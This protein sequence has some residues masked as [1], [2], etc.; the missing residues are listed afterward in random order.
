M[1]QPETLR[2][3]IPTGPRPDNY[4]VL[5]PGAG[6][7]SLGRHV[8]HDPQSR[9]YPFRAA[10]ATLAAVYH[11]R[12]VPIFDQGQLG[13]CTGNAGLGILATGPYWNDL[14]VGQQ[15]GGLAGG[16]YT[17]DEDGAKQLYS[18]VTADDDFPG[19]WPPSDTGSD[20]LSVGK[21]LVK[22]GVILGY[23]HTFDLT[24][25]L[26]ALQQFP[27]LVGTVWTD[28]MFYPDAL[29]RIGIS[30]PV[31]GGHEWIVDEFVPPGYISRGG[32]VLSTIE[33]CIG[34]TTSWSAAFGVAGR[35]YLTT[36]NFGKLLKQD[37]DV[38][39]LTPP[40]APAPTPE[41]VPGE[42]PTA[43]DVAAKVRQLLTDLGL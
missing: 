17:W 5:K 35:F 27:L 3:T 40:T 12:H 32:S 15:G 25:A 42:G 14:S 43:A 41:P 9:R 20:G 22:R 18:D 28:R 16:R 37:G 19:Q 31:D 6:H 29:G 30:G 26:A 33:A 24:S 4:T 34:G 1:T 11:E 36:T 10:A 7:F 8:N 2:Y 21:E 13:S 39:V 38:M 23:Q